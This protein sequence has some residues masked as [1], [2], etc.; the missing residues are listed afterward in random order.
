M[1]NDVLT[2]NQLSKDLGI[3]KS[4]LARWR[5][6]GTGPKYIKFGHRVLYKQSEIDRYMEL[7]TFQGTASKSIN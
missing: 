6:N 1:N 5:L 7:N 3:S 2:T 4:T